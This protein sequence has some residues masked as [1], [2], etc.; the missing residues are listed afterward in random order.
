MVVML[1]MTH[2]CAAPRVVA[3]DGAR[4]GK[5]RARGRGVPAPSALSASSASGRASRVRLRA[6]HDDIGVNA[7]ANGVAASAAAL[8]KFQ[9]ES[10]PKESAA[11]EAADAELAGLREALEDARAA[12]D[13]CIEISSVAAS[14][15]EAYSMKLRMIRERPRV[16]R[17][18][19]SGG[20]LVKAC[21]ALGDRDK[22]M[23]YACVACG[24]A[25]SLIHI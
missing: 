20:A 14:V 4:V 16:V 11:S 23:V 3:G 17:W 18:I 10:T 22:F 2:A 1:V 15:D 21:E 7:N 9:V 19:S 24:Q 5:V 25:L 6:V 8:S 12:R 13:A